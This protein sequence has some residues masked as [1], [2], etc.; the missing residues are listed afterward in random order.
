[1]DFI[2]QIQP[3]I[4]SDDLVEIK[5]VIDS[6][7]VSEN[8]ATREFER[9]IGELTGAKYVVSYANGTLALAAALMVLGL[10]SGDEVIVPDM[11]FIATANAVILAGGVPIFCDIEA[12]GWQISPSA[13]E[14]KI[15][16]KTKGIIPVHLYGMAADM[17][18]IM[19]LAKKNN[20]FVLE[21]AAESIGATYNGKHV[22][23]IGEIGMISFYANKIITTA[24][25]AVLLTSDE[26]LAKELY[27]LKNHGRSVKG[28]FQ[29]ESVGFNFSFSDLH[30]ALG[31]SQLKKLPKILKKKE[32]IFQR[33]SDAF[34]DIPQISILNAE[35]HISP[36][37][38]FS[39]IEVEDASALENY[40]KKEQIGS[41]RFFYPLHLQPCYQD[42][43]K[44]IV[45]V[46]ACIIANGGKKLF[47]NSLSA[48]V[49]G[50][51][52]PSSYSLSEEQ[53]SLVISKVTEFFSK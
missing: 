31:I 23:T 51:S 13:I 11:T 41:R 1:M 34:K 12:N 35:A 52:L 28:I 36:V 6:T 5:K 26:N 17:D 32:E 33:Y 29:H 49:R 37:Y 9:M 15:T 8:E 16:P 46:S 44:S 22:G 2:P 7:F 53:Q 45:D 4:D 30:A 20:L 24:E 47:H 25:G 18:V 3:W 43:S 39:N 40:L 50:L 27:K 48:Y 21:D 19:A 38:W 14:A 42:G 10:K